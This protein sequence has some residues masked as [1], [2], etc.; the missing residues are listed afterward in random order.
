M[1]QQLI[2]VDFAVTENRRTLSSQS[3]TLL[4]GIEVF[5]PL[6]NKYGTE[7]LVFECLSLFGPKN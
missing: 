6:Y 7:K 4:L 2:I 3:S 1:K 5:N